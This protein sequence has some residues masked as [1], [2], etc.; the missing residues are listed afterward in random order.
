VRHKTP[1]Q[2]LP[3]LPDRQYPKLPATA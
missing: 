2:T 1:M 3:K